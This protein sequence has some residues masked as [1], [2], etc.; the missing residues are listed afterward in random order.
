MLL[1][2]K[3]K[4]KK[5]KSFIQI[6]TETSVPH[7][8]IQKKKTNKKKLCANKGAQFSS[9]LILLYCGTVIIKQ[10]YLYAFA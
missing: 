1:Q 3:K 2:K 6:L 10:Q 7:S 5:K 4:K 9:F 8:A